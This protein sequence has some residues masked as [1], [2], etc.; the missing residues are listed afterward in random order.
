MAVT[1]I[2]F[3]FLV[4]AGLSVAEAST[5]LGPQDHLGAAKRLL[6]G[7]AIEQALLTELGLASGAR[8][9]ELEEEIRP[10][11]AA[12]PKNE[13]G[14]LQPS[15][16][17]Y[18]LHRYFAQKYGWYVVG[19]EPVGG[20]YSASS[21]GLVMKDR[22]PAYIES[23]FEQRLHGHGLGLREV[24]IFAATMLDLIHKESTDDL[25]AAYAHHGVD[26][27]QV[28]NSHS[29][30]EVMHTYVLLYFHS[31][32]TSSNKSMDTWR[33]ENELRNEF[34]IWPDVDMWARDLRR[35]VQAEQARRNS[36]G[37]KGSYD[38]VSEYTKEL[39]HQFGK[40]QNMEC[41]YLKGQLMDLEYKGTGRVRLS[42]FYKG[43]DDWTWTFT[44]SADY[45]RNLGALDET[46][47]NKMSVIIPNFVTSQT[48]CVTPSN[49]YS[50]CCLN[51]CEGLMSS[52]ERAIGGPT[53]EPSKIAELVSALPSDT[54]DAP[55]SMPAAQVQRLE[56][57]AK[58][59]GGS[60]P[61]HG[62]LF[63]QWMHH[64][65]PRECPYPH[66]GGGPTPIS[67]DE[68][69]KMVGTTEASNAEM[70]RHSRHQASEEEL[71]AAMTPEA[72]V[73]A[74]PWVPV[75]ELVMAHRQAAPTRGGGA[76]KVA[77]FVAA[78]VAL[79][80]QAQRGL[81]TLLGGGARKGVGL[82]ADKQHFV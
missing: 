32:D 5:F 31:F 9:H 54:V 34:V 35:T 69:I 7:G 14:N 56:E 44:E 66:V 70:K 19:L 11:F 53:A 33:M 77:S 68:W 67:P 22:V 78:L 47:P 36:F 81:D 62:R 55:R 82:K 75:E 20:S 37:S 15:V 30:D 13:Y 26:P 43:A 25:H 48:N 18:A 38:R 76:L 50:V 80:W 4:L 65:Y 58:L 1:A 59:H 29:M 40:W 10:L 71:A 79:A 46:D 28:L 57:I 74:L 16:T 39:G 6:T 61:L 45:L 8:M 64:A 17:R 42:E 72:T 2:A 73:E 63:A 12:M 3:P 60:I 41:Q 21:P 51:E 52:L 23:L 27:S 49:L 24:A